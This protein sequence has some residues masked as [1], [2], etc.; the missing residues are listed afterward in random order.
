MANVTGLHA[1]RKERATG[2]KKPTASERAAAKSERE[3]EAADLSQ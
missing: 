1:A 3:R 2:R